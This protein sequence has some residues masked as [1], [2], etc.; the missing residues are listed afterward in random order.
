MKTL[1]PYALLAIIAVALDQ[2][3]KLLVETHLVMHDKVDL[4]PFLALFRT[5]NT[6][7]AFS[8]FS[9][10][11]DKGLILLSLAVVGFVL[12]LAGRT[13]PDQLAAR[14]GFALII[15]GAI[16]NVIDR[17]FYGH[18]IDYILFHTPVWSFA[19]FNLADS[20]ITVG[21]VLVLFEEFFG[22]RRQRAER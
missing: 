7:V 11:G 22:G 15:G 5:Y 3:I 4:L 6:G 21:A 2:W 14:A 1:S 9:W 20:F 13:R 17:T 8:M 19:V 16:G 18:V 12:Y 10:I